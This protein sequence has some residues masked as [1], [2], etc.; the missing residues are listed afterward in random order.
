MQSVR[1][2]DLKKGHHLSH[3]IK[4][5]SVSVAIKI[6]TGVRKSRVHANAKKIFCIFGGPKSGKGQLI[7]ELVESFGVKVISAES[8]ILSALPKKLPPSTEGKLDTT[9]LI[10]ELRSKPELVTLEWIFELVKNEVLR[11]P[12]TIHVIDLLPNSKY[13]LRNNTLFTDVAELLTKFEETCPVAFAMYLYIDREN[14]N[15]QLD[16]A[17]QLKTP[18]GVTA[19]G[20][21]NDEADS[22]ATKRRHKY[23]EE[24]LKPVNNYFRGSDRLIEVDV[25]AV[26]RE[27]AWFKIVRMLASF[28]LSERQNNNLIVIFIVDRTPVQGLI[29]ANVRVINLIDITDEPDANFELL[30]DCLIYHITELGCPNICYIVDIKGSSFE[31]AQNIKPLPS[32]VYELGSE[33]KLSE[34]LNK[35]QRNMLDEDASTWD[36]VNYT[37]YKAPNNMTFLYTSDIPK[38]AAEVISTT[39]CHKETL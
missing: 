23:F 21:I 29:D 31:N 4:G 32:L 11:Y 35:Y 16:N 13:I 24:A 3:D 18:D 37:G 28:D 10:H 22:A 5:R 38:R 12:D 6:G 39:Y 15:K 2:K 14:L 36:C 8:L 19:P 20:G 30:I 27:R 7:E 25:S 1:N 26:S 9:S 33:C 34:H 17:A